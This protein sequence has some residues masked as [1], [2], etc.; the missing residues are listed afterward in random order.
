MFKWTLAIDDQ[1]ILAELA[2]KAMQSRRNLIELAALDDKPA[3]VD[4]AE[5]QII[6]N[7]FNNLDEASAASSSSKTAFGAV[8]KFDLTPRSKPGKKAS[9]A[10]SKQ[11]DADQRRQAIMNMFSEPAK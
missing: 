1:K 10:N 8:G 11:Q 9:G 2:Q 6:G 3:E 5:V 7:I 4:A